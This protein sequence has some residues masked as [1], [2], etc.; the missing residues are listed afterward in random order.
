MSQLLGGD[1]SKRI[2]GLFWGTPLLFRCHVRERCVES[3]RIFGTRQWE[4]SLCNCLATNA[5]EHTCFIAC[6]LSGLDNARRRHEENDYYRCRSDCHLGLFLCGTGP[7]R[8]RRENPPRAAFETFWGR[9]VL[10]FLTILFLPL[11]TYAI[12]QEK[13]SERRARQDRRFMAGYSPL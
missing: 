13:L 4:S 6:H 3:P 11:I 5:Q 8:T 12:L 2:S 1:G 10:G 7:G 9:V